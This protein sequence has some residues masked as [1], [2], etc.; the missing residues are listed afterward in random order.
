MCRREGNEILG[1]GNLEGISRAD[2]VRR[3]LGRAAVTTSELAELTL[4]WV[5][6]EVTT[7]PLGVD[8]GGWPVEFWAILGPTDPR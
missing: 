4:V 7:L 5:R 8:D 2:R 1:R 3:F 6:F